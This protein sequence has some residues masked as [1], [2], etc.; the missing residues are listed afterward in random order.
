MAILLVSLVLMITKIAA[1]LTWSDGSYSVRSLSVDLCKD[2]AIKEK[3]HAP[4]II[5]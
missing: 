2:Y 3:N 5:A 1:G 4:Y